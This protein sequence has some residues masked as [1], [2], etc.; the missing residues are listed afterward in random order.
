MLRGERDHARQ[1]LEA[2]IDIGFEGFSTKTG[3]GAN[4][5][6]WTVSRI[7]RLLNLLDEHGFR[8]LQLKAVELLESFLK[9]S[10]DSNARED[11]L[12]LVFIALLDL[13]ELEDALS[14]ADRMTRSVS[15]WVMYGDVA[16][17]QA[18]ARRTDEALA[19]AERVG[20]A[21][22]RVKAKARVAAVLA[23][24]GRIELAK[25]V[26]P[27]QASDIEVNNAHKAIASALAANGEINEAIA[28]AN[29]IS[30]MFQRAFVQDS[31]SG[32][33]AEA[34]ELEAAVALAK[35]ISVRQQRAQALATVGEVLV[36]GG[37]I[38][39]ARAVLAE[40][41]RTALWQDPV[42]ESVEESRARLERALSSATSQ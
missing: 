14:T 18:E 4:S 11:A 31:L 10:P 26:L 21:T 39:L 34:G 28:Y 8:E 3:F 42:D 20:N 41:P 9:Y 1:V 23:E 33:L 16:V 2:A 36:A 32:V 27:S 17:A 29:A 12:Y 37:E 7:S 15:K 30:G 35:S 19:T 22:F 40:M 6:L 13:G 38:E 5:D 24:Q 25:D